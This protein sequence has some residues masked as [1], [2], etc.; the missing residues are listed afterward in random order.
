MNEMNE[1]PFILLLL[2]FQ[3]VTFYLRDAMTVE[4]FLAASCLKK[5]LNPAEHFVRVKKRRDMAN[6]KYFVPH[7]SDLIETYVRES[8]LFFFPVIVSLRASRRPCCD[9]MLD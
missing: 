3:V 8:F 6:L 5:G 4:D 1:R 9:L 7:R 2:L